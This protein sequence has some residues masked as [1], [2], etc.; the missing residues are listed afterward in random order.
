MTMMSQ[1]STVLACYP[2]RFR[3]MPPGQPE[4]MSELDIDT[5]LAWRGR[6]VRDRQGEKIGTL[7]DVYLD[8]GTDRPAYAGVNTG[9]FG[10]HEHVVPLSGV[11]ER[12]GDLLVPHSREQVLG[13]PSADAETALDEHQEQALFEHYGR[14]ERH[15]DGAEMVRSEEEV[16]VDVRPVK[17]AERVRLRKHVVTEHVQKTV[18]VRREVVQV[19]HEPPPE[20]RIVSEEDAGEAERP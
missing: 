3:P 19:E 8:R 17:R 15:A 1:V 9:L 14:P 12:D 20:G 10:R 13:A 4:T 7:G 16:D 11:E 2:L 6:T 18:P 5:V